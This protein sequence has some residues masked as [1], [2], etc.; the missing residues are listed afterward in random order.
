MKVR[1]PEWKRVPIDGVELA[2]WDWP[3]EGPALLFVHATGFHARSWDQVIRH[4]PGRRCIAPDLRGHGRSDKP[5]PPYHWNAFGRD[6][7]LLTDAMGLT[8]AV[9][10]GHSMGGHSVVEAAL[11]RPRSFASLLL[12]DPTIFPEHRYGQPALDSSFIARR[13]NVWSSPDEMFERFRSRPPFVSWKPEVLK[14]YCEFGLLPEGDHFVLACPPPIEHSIYQHSTEVSAN[15]HPRLRS[16][17]IP[18]TVIRGGIPWTLDAFNLNASPTDPQLAAILPNA[19]DVLLEGKSHYIPM[20]TP[21]LI[22]E[23]LR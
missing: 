7:A 6:M 15:L 16:V 9:G 5:E 1:S 8:D 19:R 20:E 23:Y 2:V 10:I 13:R 18:A 17:E 4:F 12:I 21:E 11:L 14:D 22:A 3:G